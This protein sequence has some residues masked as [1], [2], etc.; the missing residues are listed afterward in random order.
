M[1]FSAGTCDVVE[2]DLVEVEVVGGDDRAEGP[3]GHAGQVGRDDQ[4][5]D[6]L[7]LR[8]VG[9]GAHEGEDDVGVVGA[10][11]PHLLTVDDEVVAV[12]HRPGP[13]AGQV[14]SGVGLAHPERGGDLGPED[15]HRPPL[16]LLLGAEAQQG[17]RDD[18]QALRVE[19]GVDAAASQLLSVHELLEQRGVP[20]AVLRRVA[21]HEPAGV[22]HR[23]LPPPGPRRDVSARMG[24]LRGLGLGRGVLVQP[25]REL[26]AE[27]FGGLVEVELHDGTSVA[28]WTAMVSRA[29]RARCTC[30]LPEQRLAHL[31]PAHVEL[32]VVL[33]GVAEAAEQLDPVAADQALAVAGSHLGHR[34]R[35]PRPLVALGEGEGG[36]L[37]E[38]P[39]PLDGDERIHGQVLH[40]LEAADRHAELV[41]V[42]DVDQ[43]QLEHPLAGARP[44]WRPAR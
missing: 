30:G 21:G 40:G 35:R 6:P 37:A 24:A 41:A 4:A 23:A 38:R 12:Q 9:V 14:R 17:R 2:E 39:P 34:R 18:G 31:R 19:G 25:C 5:A 3:P 43:H 16:L 7:V 8:R 20:A 42:L 10:R 26:A 29:T 28:V 44:W 22:E 11:G 27:G 13:Q 33:P 1:R 32:Q 36:V 15:G